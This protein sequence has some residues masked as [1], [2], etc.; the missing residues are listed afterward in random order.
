M[1]PIRSFTFAVSMPRGPVALCAMLA[2][3]AG[4][5][6]APPTRTATLNF[7]AATG[8]ATYD[9]PTDQMWA[10]CTMPAI[11]LT[12]G[13]VDSLRIATAGIGNVDVG[14]IYK[15]ADYGLVPSATT[16]LSNGESWLPIPSYRWGT[17]WGP[18]QRPGTP[19][20][21]WTLSWTLAY[22]IRPTGAQGSST[23]TFNCQ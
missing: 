19:R 12:G 2:Y 18:G 10:T 11:H 21:G 1:R 3:A 20:V 15:G 23:L 4:C 13:P 8:S 9:Y 17:M 7:S 14:P 6:T 22:K 5:T 16:S